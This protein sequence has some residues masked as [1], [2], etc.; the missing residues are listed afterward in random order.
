MIDAGDV[1]VQ[2]RRGW[3]R[4]PILALHGFS[5]RVEEGDIFGLLGPNGAGKSTAMYG[6][7]GLIRPDRGTIRV[8]DRPPAPGGRMY[9]DIGYLPEEPQYPLYLTVEELVTFYGSLYREPLS[10][11]RVQEAIERVGLQGFRDLRLDRCSKGMK[12]KAG[13]A[14][15]LVK[16][17]R[18]LFLDEPTRGLDPVI[19]KEFRDIL[20]DMN[21]Q[22]T[23]IV[24]NSHVLSEVE[25]ICNRVA[26]VNRGQVVVQDRLTNLLRTDVENYEVLFDAVE[27]VPDYVQIISKTGTEIRG[28][29]PK[30]RLA[31]FFQF[32]GG[33]GV[34]VYHCS[35]RKMS[36]EDA[37]M[38]VVK[39]NSKS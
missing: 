5:L 21:R 18:L 14:A 32:T 16:R 31:E 27:P 34:K 36:L 29:I 17:P 33:R 25:M 6:F 38:N 10:R 8:F 39:G 20:L 11:P 4:P 22:G 3:F 35:M 24:L 9:N 13:I 2:F 7:L 15:C 12:Q 37:F 23:T 26:I 19:V 28:T 30:D 1:T